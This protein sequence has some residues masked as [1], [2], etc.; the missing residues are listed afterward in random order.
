MIA[1]DLTPADLGRTITWRDRHGHHTL[2][3]DHLQIEHGE[4]RTLVL[5]RGTETDPWG[6]WVLDGRRKVEIVS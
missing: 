2:T 1:A 6:G 3:L 4:R 5:V